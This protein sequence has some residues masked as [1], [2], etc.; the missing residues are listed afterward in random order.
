MLLQIALMVQLRPL[1]G[2]EFLLTVTGFLLVVAA[3]AITVR[4]VVPIN[5]T[6]HS[7]NFLP[8]PSGLADTTSEMGRLPSSKNCPCLHSIVDAGNRLSPA[9]GPLENRETM[10]RMPVFGTCA[11]SFVLANTCQL[12]FPAMVAELRIRSLCARCRQLSL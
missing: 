11:L 4:W 10:G 3:T 8:P 6:I 1:T 5:A 2:M 12:F 7:W 9:A